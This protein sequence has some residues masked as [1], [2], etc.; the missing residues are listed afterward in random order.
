MSKIINFGEVTRENTQ[1]HDPSWQQIP[2]HPNRILILNASE[3][4]G[5]RKISTEKLLY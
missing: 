3:N 4:N 5:M 1:E 2:N